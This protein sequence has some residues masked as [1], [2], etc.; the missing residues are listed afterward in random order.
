[1]FDK[2][3]QLMEVK[4]KADEIKAK[5]SRD[6]FMYYGQDLQNLQ[7]EVCR[8]GRR[9]DYTL[10]GVEMEIYLLAVQRSQRLDKLSDKLKIPPDT[11]RIILDDF[12]QKGLILYSSD[13][14]AFL[15]L[16]MKG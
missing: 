16:A 14:K 1:M 4:K 15:S 2:L 11:V 9:K 7:I 13:K 6:D 3:N 8:D 10:R 12:E 5:D